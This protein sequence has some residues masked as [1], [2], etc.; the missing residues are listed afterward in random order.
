MMNRF[1]NV[2]RTPLQ[3]SLRALGAAVV[4][5]C[6][7]GV[8]QFSS[9]TSAQAQSSSSKSE[10]SSSKKD[11]DKKDAPAAAPSAA[12][13]AA[14]T[15]PSNEPIQVGLLSSIPAPAIA[16]RAWMT[17]DVTSGQI[18]A[19]SNADMKIEPASLTKIMTAYVAFNA[20][21]EKRLTTDQQAN[22]SQVAWKTKGTQL[23]Q[24]LPADCHETLYACE[25]L[26]EVPANR[27]SQESLFATWEQIKNS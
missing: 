12:A 25:A 2:A 16:A 17:M 10:K 4:L 11:A 20:I 5:A 9:V 21:K 14:T 22:V 7:L 23:Y 18:V 13:V 15:P 24:Q 3:S 8:G 27:P 26:T 1:K 6:A 19:S